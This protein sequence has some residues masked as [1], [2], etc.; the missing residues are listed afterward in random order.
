LRATQILAA[1]GCENG[2]CPTIYRSDRG[3]LIVQGDLAHAEGVHLGDGEQS[4]E[5][6]VDL[7]LEAARAL[8]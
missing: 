2:D 8:A 3:T 1:T 5:I 4:V 7:L 6:P